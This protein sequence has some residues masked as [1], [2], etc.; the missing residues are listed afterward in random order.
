MKNLKSMRM[1]IAE[2]QEMEIFVETSFTVVIGL[3]NINR[4]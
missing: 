2:I 3:V 4:K 1:M